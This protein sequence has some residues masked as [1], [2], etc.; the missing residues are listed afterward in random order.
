MTYRASGSS[1]A[2]TAVGDGGEAEGQALD[3]GDEQRVVRAALDGDDGGAAV[4]DDDAD[5]ASCWRSFGQDEVG[6]ALG[7]E[8]GGAG[9]AELALVLGREV[10]LA[11]RPRARRPGTPR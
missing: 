7:R 1:I 10:G 8:Q 9:L 3:A 5:G 11:H 4:R 6:E 2:R